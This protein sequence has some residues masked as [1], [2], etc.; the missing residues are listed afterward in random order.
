MAITHTTY[1][2]GA[3]DVNFTIPFPYIE[4][5]HVKV[6]I[7][8]TATT[9][10][11][12]DTG[13]NRVVLSSGATAGSKIKVKRETPGRTEA[14]ST[15]LV[16]FQDGS[17]LSE[18]DLDKVTQQLLYITQEGEEVGSSSLPLDWDGHYT[19][20]GKRIKNIQATPGA[21]QDVTSKSYVDGLSL[22]GSAVSIPQAWAKL[23][24]N[25]VFND[26]D[27][28][29]I[30]LTSPTPVSNTAA[31]YIVSVNGLTKR[32]NVDFTITMTASDT[33]VLKLIL[34][35]GGLGSS[36]IVNIMNFGVSRSI[37]E[38]PIVPA[39]TSSV[40]L[41]VKGLS[42]QSGDLIQ[43]NNSADSTLFKVDKDGDV[44]AVDITASGTATSAQLNVGGGFGSTGSTIES[45]GD[46]KT[47]GQVD[48]GGGSGSSGGRLSNAGDITADGDLTI[49]GA[50]VLNS[51][52]AVSG[53]TTLAGGAGSS[54]V[55]VATS[56][57]ITTDGTLVTGGEITSGSHID[58]LTGSLKF[59]G[60][61]AYTIRNI[62]TAAA[63]GSG[64]EDVTGHTNFKILGFRRTLTP[65]STSS[66]FLVGG[67]ANLKIKSDNAQFAA[68][69][70]QVVWVEGAQNNIGESP[71]ESSSVI[72]GGSSGVEIRDRMDQGG[73]T[74]DNYGQQVVP[75]S[76]TFEPGTIETIKIDITGRPS[77]ADTDYV[78]LVRAKTSFWVM[79][80]LK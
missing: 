67:Y 44:S 23:G 73:S 70:M 26:S 68:A 11:T 36:D 45:D 61:K 46:I 19:A 65:I 30:T 62:Y 9:A 78:R 72:M 16:D 33:Y 74:A 80:L 2:A 54:G 1:T 13:N 50:S 5:S 79:E 49:T 58:L 55:T 76:F 17:V 18:T 66:V 4:T 24:S 60:D 29:E 8:G 15:L 53:Q 57:N 22:Y 52:L 63:I 77:T 31:L 14:A 20:G 43:V 27:G 64:D 47:D 38:M 42:G 40:G 28:Y 21:D 35:D 71:K 48:W 75:L 37:L 6:E 51:T 34:A 32:P 12:V 25:F 39:T 59:A 41:T 56:G 10:F 69:E 7:D 3:G